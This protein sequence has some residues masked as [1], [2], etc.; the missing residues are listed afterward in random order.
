MGGFMS[1]IKLDV[2]R[3]ECFIVQLNKNRE[4]IVLRF[5]KDD[6]G[7]LS[8]KLIRNMLSPYEKDG[9]DIMDIERLWT[10]KGVDE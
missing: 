4:F 7:Y 2:K 8:R 3:T 1:N 9:W 5:Y 6:Y 10:Y